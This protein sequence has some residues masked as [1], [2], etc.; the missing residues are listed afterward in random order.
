MLSVHERIVNEA[1]DKVLEATKELQRL[2]AVK[3]RFNKAFGDEVDSGG[4]IKEGVLSWFVEINSPKYQR[5]STLIVET[6]IVNGK[7]HT[8]LFFHDNLGNRWSLNKRAVLNLWD[9]PR[10]F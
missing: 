5:S 7:P 3:V 4:R 10:E 9:I 8:P 1:I 6:P 2:G